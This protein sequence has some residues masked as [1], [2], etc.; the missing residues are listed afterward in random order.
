[1][2]VR[3][4]SDPKPSTVK[5]KPILYGHHLCPFVERVRIALKLLNLYDH[6]THCQIDLTQRPKWYRH[7]NPSRKVPTL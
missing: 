1:M 2:E 7:L 6:V 3:N 4:R 5:G